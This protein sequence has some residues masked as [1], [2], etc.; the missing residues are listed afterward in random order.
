MVI[1]DGIRR[2]G[3]DIRATGW[4]ECVGLASTSELVAASTTKT[5]NACKNIPIRFICCSIRIPLRN[6]IPTPKAHCARRRILGIVI[7]QFIELIQL[8]GVKR[9]RRISDVVVVRLAGSQ[10]HV[11]DIVTVEQVVNFDEESEHLGVFTQIHVFIKSLS[12]QR[13]GRQSPFVSFS[14]SISFAVALCV[15]QTR[16]D[17]PHHRETPCARNRQTKECS[18]PT[19]RE[20]HV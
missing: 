9:Q 2:A 8:I 20:T 4:F 13:V 17:I 14:Q 12:T 3:L 15:R 11:Q 6:C 10:V 1:G 7:V 18:L 16:S 5:I 19:A